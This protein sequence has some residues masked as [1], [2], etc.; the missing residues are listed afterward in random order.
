MS[1][2]RDP[3]DQ[4]IGINVARQYTDRWYMSSTKSFRWFGVKCFI[5][6][7]LTKSHVV[8]SGVGM[9]TGRL[10]LKALSQK[11]ITLKDCEFA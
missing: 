8:H 11:V 1:A 6:E 7:M 4:C 3:L 2:G 9:G 10:P 5:K